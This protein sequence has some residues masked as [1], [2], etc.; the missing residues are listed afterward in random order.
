MLRAAPPSLESIVLTKT[1]I[2]AGGAGG[3]C[4]RVTTDVS[5]GVIHVI[6]AIPACPVRTRSGHSGKC[7]A[8][9][10]RSMLELA[11]CCGRP[12]LTT[13]QKRA[14]SISSTVS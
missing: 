14:L 2:P 6:P 3:T 8:L 1:S 4:C 7:R 10:A 5:I 13:Q 9:A 12:R 11:G